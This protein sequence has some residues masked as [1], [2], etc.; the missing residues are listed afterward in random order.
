MFTVKSK[1]SLKMKEL[2]SCNALEPVWYGN[3]VIKRIYRFI[4]C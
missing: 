2:V 1:P 3:A 4:F